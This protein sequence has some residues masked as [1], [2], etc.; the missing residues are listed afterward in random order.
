[1]S[2]NNYALEARNITKR[3]GR[4]QALHGIS[5]NLKPG[6]M[7]GILGDNGAGKSTLMKILSG[8]HAPTTG[9]MLVNGQSVAF[10]SVD[11][12]RSYGIECVYQ[13]LA[14]VNTLSVYHN[15]F[16]NRELRRSGTPFLD[17]KAMRER[18]AAALQDI[19]VNV[20]SVDEE[21]GMLSGGQR[22]AIAIARAVSSNAKVLLLDEP[23]AAMGAR[24]ASMIIALIERLKARGDVSLI[25]IAHNYAQTLDVADRVMMVQRGTC[26][27]EGYSAGTSVMQ[28]LEIVKRE[29]RAAVQ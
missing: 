5:L 14:L 20:P 25:M 13:D 8:Y 16:L 17:H 23:L 7:L 26:T 2:D 6:E 28:L 9:E 1:M 12:A 27:F 29:Y 15:M 3:F 19:G 22:Q 4:I 18:A 24:E 10:N 21:V 11:H